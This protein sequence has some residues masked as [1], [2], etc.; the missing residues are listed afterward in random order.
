MIGRDVKIGANCRMHARVTLYPGVRLHDRVIVHS[1]VVLGAD[2][3]GYVTHEGRHWKFPQAGGLEI[4]NDAEIGANTTIDRGSLGVTQ[5]GEQV[6]IDNLV[7]IAHNVKV[8][9]RTL[10]AAQTG[11]AGS[12][13]IGSDVV[14]GGQVGIADHCRLQDGCIVGAQAGIP[15]GKVI[16]S[17]VTVWGTPARPLDRVKK[18]HAWYTRLPELAARLRSLEKAGSRTS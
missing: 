9:D 13:T 3:F 5:I 10:I 1:G 6:K 14:I 8:G 11:I 7:H 17:G 4:G 15:S 18:Q 2:G 12:C 16:N